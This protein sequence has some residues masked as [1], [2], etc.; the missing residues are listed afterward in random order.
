MSRLRL[1]TR[2][3]EYRVRLPADGLATTNRKKGATMTADDWQPIETAPKDGTMFL[4]W[5]RPHGTGFAVM[6]FYDSKNG[7]GFVDF[8]RDDWF[9]PQLTHWQPIVG[10]V[11]ESTTKAGQ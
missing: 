10:P 9:D 8:M 2:A 7:D 3:D 4:A 11:A 5:Y 6:A 1:T